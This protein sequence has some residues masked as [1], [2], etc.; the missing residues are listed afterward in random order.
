MDLQEKIDNF[1]IANAWDVDPDSFGELK[2]AGVKALRLLS[3][4][5]WGFRDEQLGMR[6]MGL[7]YTTILSLVPLLAVSFSVLKALGV[8]THLEIVLYNVLEPLGPKGVDISMKIIKFVENVNVGVLGAVG[9]STLFYTV[10]SNISKVE[11]ALNYIWDIRDTRSLAERFSNYLSVLLIGPVLVF[12]AMGLTG[13]LMNSGIAQELIAVHP[14]GTLI[15]FLGKLIPYVFVCA[16]FTLTYSFL[17]NTNVHLRAAFAGGLFAAI[18][19]E[20]A[21]WA[22]AA[23]VVSSSRYS[24]IYSG[25]AV[26][27]L[28]II[29]IDLSW[30]ILLIGA[31]VSFYYQYP[32]FFSATSTP[33]VLNDELREEFAVVI[34]YLI[35]CNF[36]RNRRRWT[37][38]SLIERVGLPV[39][40]LKDV[41]ETLEGESLIIATGANGPYLPARDIGTITVK[42]I[43]DAVRTPRKGSEAL[44]RGAFSVPPVDAIIKKI[45]DAITAEIDNITL[46]DLV[47]SE[48]AGDS[49]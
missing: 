3:I 36:Y 7:V 25:F 24:L 15:F 27:I 34:M 16:A 4:A 28:F 18:L 10:I 47:V 13:S 45:D 2:A 5:V 39:S 40:P 22:F 38:D 35:G 14:F 6:A 8:Q 43:I 1:F 26:G 49:K 46:K 9:L 31:R 12:S 48:E 29:W 11:A 19:W 33:Y 23:F 21:G 32:R 20:T 30:L 44:K 37:F 17:P 41:L 42:E